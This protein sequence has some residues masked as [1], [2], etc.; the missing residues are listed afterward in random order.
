MSI[1]SPSNNVLMISSIFIKKSNKKLRDFRLFH[2][3][4]KD[5]YV[6]FQ[7]EQV[8]PAKSHRP[9]VCD[10]SWHKA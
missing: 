10:E 7:N 6:E 9:S 4:W 2:K 8:K 3:T 1:Y 5:I